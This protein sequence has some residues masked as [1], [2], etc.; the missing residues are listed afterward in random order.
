ML[1]MKCNMTFIILNWLFCNYFVIVY[2]FCIFNLVRLYKWCWIWFHA[3]YLQIRVYTICRLSVWDTCVLLCS[4]HL[5]LLLFI[6]H[7]VIW[8]WLR[9][10]SLHLWHSLFHDSF[11]SH[12][13]RSVPLLFIKRF[14]FST[15]RM[16]K[17]CHHR[18]QLILS[19]AQSGRE[20]TLALFG[21]VCLSIEEIKL[22]CTI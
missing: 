18:D 19:G 16:D 21:M 22:Q 2:L 1:V 7:S 14:V 17:F 15:N 20:K 3:V 13:L 9:P 11:L 4:I 6:S 5:D 8:S 12:T 10:H